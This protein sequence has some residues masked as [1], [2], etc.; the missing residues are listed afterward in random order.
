MNQSITHICTHR[1]APHRTA[2][3][4]TAPHRTA[5]HRTKWNVCELKKIG[6]KFQNTESKTLLTTLY[7]ST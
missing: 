5:P 1:T 6:Q 4:R 7:Y 2:P 3:H